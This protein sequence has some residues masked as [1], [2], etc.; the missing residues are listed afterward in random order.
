MRANP[1]AFPARRCLCLRP[2]CSKPFARALVRSLCSSAWAAFLPASRPTRSCARVPI[3]FSFIPRSLCAAPVSLS[4]SRKSFLPASSATA[5]VTWPKRSAT[6]FSTLPRDGLDSAHRDASSLYLSRN[7]A[8]T[9]AHFAGLR[10]KREKNMA[11]SQ[12]FGKLVLRLMLGT[13]LLFH[14]VHKVIHGIGPITA[15]VTAHH[16]P[17]ALAYG[18]YSGE[19]L[20]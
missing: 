10:F 16:L 14:G 6:S 17:P 2:R 20:G 1:A 5:S 4:R 19:I 13:L 7:L 8:R 18:V 11:A 9:A 12:D 15:M 3:S